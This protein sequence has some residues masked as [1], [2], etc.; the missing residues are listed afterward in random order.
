MHHPV[1]PTPEEKGSFEIPWKPV[2]DRNILEVRMEVYPL[3]I[4]G[5]A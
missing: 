1:H 5:T 2:A 3:D 4:I